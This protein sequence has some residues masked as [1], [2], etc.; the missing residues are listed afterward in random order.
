[1]IEGT[2]DAARRQWIHTA[3]VEHDSFRQL[4][5]RASSRY[6]LIKRCDTHDVSECIICPEAEGVGTPLAFQDEFV[7]VFPAR[8]QPSG[9]PGYA[10][11][12]TRSHIKTL[13]DLGDDVIGPVMKRV[14]DV[15]RAVE[16]ASGADGTTIRQN[17]NPPG[18]EIG[19]VHFHVVPRFI[20][21]D[22]W[23]A[24]AQELDSQSRHQQAASQ[25][26]VS[27]RPMW[28]GRTAALTC[29]RASTWLPHIGSLDI[30][31]TE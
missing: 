10:L 28:D 14:R 26:S 9:N 12:V 22:Y 6:P 5:A 3:A 23:N 25:P 2:G 15:A 31:H 13:C 29:T 17:N 11:V 1:M 20:G 27:A 21:D 8:W 4:R 18:Q 24:E 19:H 16:L 30:E 7:A